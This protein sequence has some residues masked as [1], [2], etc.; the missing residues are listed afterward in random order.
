[1]NF[2]RLF[3]QAETEHYVIES[4]SC[5]NG[6][7]AKFLPA[8]S[9]YET[10]RACHFAAS[11]LKCNRRSNTGDAGNINRDSFIWGDATALF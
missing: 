8:F 10:T 9:Y 7:I 3:I 4:F 1:M 11:R 6:L 2:A 5:L